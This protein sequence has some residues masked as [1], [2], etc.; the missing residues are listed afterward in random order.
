MA[1]PI[2]KLGHLMIVSIQSELTDSD[3]D[4]LRDDLLQRA[5]VNGSKG[6]VI[7]VS[8]MQIMDSFAGRTLSTMAQ[9]LRLRGVEAVVVGIQPEV[10]FSMVQ[11]GLHLEHVGTALDLEAGV[12]SLQHHFQGG[13]LDAQ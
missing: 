6:A 1:V 5:G 4:G 8:A 10:A 7:D 9:M 11:L 12:E 13:R 3:W 2:L